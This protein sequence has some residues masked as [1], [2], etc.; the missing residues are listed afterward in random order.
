MKT[1]YLGYIYVML[2]NLQ[3]ALK[4]IDA[5]KDKLAKYMHLT[6]V[7]INEVQS[8]SHNVELVVLILQIFTCSKLS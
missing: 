4:S 2:Y 7:H 3:S 8:V 5:Q 6:K 1:S